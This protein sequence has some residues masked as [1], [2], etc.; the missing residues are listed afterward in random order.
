MV[1]LFFFNKRNRTAALLKFVAVVAIILA[2]PSWYNYRTSGNFSLVTNTGGENLFWGNSDHPYFRV[3][4][5]GHYSISQW[6]SNSPSVL[7]IKKL[8]SWHG[9]S[10]VDE[11]FRA[12]ALDYIQKNLFRQLADFSGS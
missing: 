5:Q 8:N 9:G 4:L 10:T 6:D 12:A 2:V 7:L 11:V 1:F 3:L